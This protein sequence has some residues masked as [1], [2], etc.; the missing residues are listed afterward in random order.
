MAIEI[1]ANAFQLKGYRLMAHVVDGCRLR[2]T[3][4][5]GPNPRYFEYDLSTGALLRVLNFTGGRAIT[6]TA[7][8]DDFE[9]ELELAVDYEKELQYDVTGST[10]SS[11]SH[12]SYDANEVLRQL[13]IGINM[14][15]WLSN[16]VPETDGKKYHCDEVDQIATVLTNQA[17][18]VKQAVQEL[19]QM[20]TKVNWAEVLN[21]KW[22]AGGYKFLMPLE[23]AIRDGVHPDE[24]L[25]EGETTP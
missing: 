8:D 5:E 10:F 17:V 3:F 11:S 21:I 6:R 25:D 22:H 20:D 13:Q 18:D 23:T 7:K 15:K 2:C 9:V 12:E 4:D 24:T 14:R 1:R 16:G 19:N